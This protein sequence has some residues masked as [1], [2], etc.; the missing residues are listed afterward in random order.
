MHYS[1]WRVAPDDNDNMANYDASWL[2]LQ[3][4]QG[5]ANICR[6]PQLK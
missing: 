4:C 6:E 1:P 5:D 3:R 2:D